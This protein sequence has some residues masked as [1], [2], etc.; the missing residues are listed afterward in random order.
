MSSWL[1]LAV[2]AAGGA[3]GSI[4]RYGITLGMMSIPGGSSMLGTTTANVVGCAAI[5][6]LAEYSLLSETF[7]PRIVLGLRV[8][9]LGALTTFSTFAAESMLLAGEQRWPVAVFYVA[10]NLFLGWGALW[11]A[12]TL[13][14]GWLA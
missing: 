14:K 9:F 10:A 2:V 6:A 8:G 7:S 5:G 3:V 12:A 11:L 4:A 13:V 1:N